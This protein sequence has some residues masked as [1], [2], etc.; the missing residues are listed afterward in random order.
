MSVLQFKIFVI[1]M[2]ATTGLIGGLIT[3]KVSLSKKG[4]RLLT[5]GNAFAGGIF[6]GAGVIH[7]LG[8]SVEKFGEMAGI[9]YPWAF[10]ICG[11]GFLGILMLEKVIVKSDESNI[12]ND[13]YSI[14]PYILLLVLSVHSV[15]AGISLGLEKTMTT[16][17]VIF[18][19]LIA[20]KGSASFA[21]GVGL[22]T[23]GVVTGTHKKLVAL[24]ASMTPLGI[25]F[26]TVL[27]SLA[28][29]NAIKFEA[30]FDALAAGT[31]LYIAI[32]D[33]MSEIYHNRADRFGKFLLI[34]AG[35]G[36]M[37]IIAIWT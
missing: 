32:M 31:F 11:I 15:I 8:D 29:T 3:L 10:L 27:T 13:G 37:A 1:I 34:A 20:H 33:I 4:K 21:L 26:G 7:L 22:R 25:Y 30:V 23:S 28:T 9:D 36:F 12:S 2:L 35:F 14:Y 6:L 24:F 17:I 19:A 16:T 18:I 5:L